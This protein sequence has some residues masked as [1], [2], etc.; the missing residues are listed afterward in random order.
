MT[1]AFGSRDRVLLP[2]VARRRAEL[3]DQARWVT[4]SDCGHVPMFD[5]A[6]A[7]VDLLL[8]SSDPAT[9]GALGKPVR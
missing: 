9:A 3:P 6:A 8:R 2:G 7:V 4:L 1:V 5:D